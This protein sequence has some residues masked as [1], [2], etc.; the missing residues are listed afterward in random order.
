MF[1]CGQ[2]LISDAGAD[3][4]SCWRC[5]CHTRS[6]VG[7]HVHSCSIWIMHRSF[8]LPMLTGELYVAG[9]AMSSCP[10][11]SGI[12][13][14]TGETTEPHSW[15]GPQLSQPP[16]LPRHQPHETRHCT[17]EH[18]RHTVPACARDGLSTPELEQRG[19]VTHRASLTRTSYTT[20]AR[21]TARRPQAGLGGRHQYIGCGSTL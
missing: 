5:E 16:G 9:S 15:K 19:A 12:A 6:E 3:E 20:P 1:P 2:G 10:F 11:Q 14:R 18:R 21:S 8:L 13:A 17:R 4:S 7:L